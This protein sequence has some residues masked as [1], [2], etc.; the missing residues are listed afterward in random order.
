MTLT[1]FIDEYTLQ[2]NQE[3][4]LISDSYIAKTN[5]DSD[6][7]NMMKYS[8]LSNGKR[9]RPLLTLLIIQAFG[10]KINTNL[11]KSALPV[12]LIHAYSLVHDDLPDMDDDEYRRGELTT[13][14]KF[15]SDNAIL[16]GDALLTHAFLY[17]SKLPIESEI[18]IKLIEEMSNSAQEMVLGQQKDIAQINVDS[19]NKLENIHKLKTSALLRYSI[20]AGYYLQNKKPINNDDLMNLTTFAN[21]YGIAYQLVDDFK[22]LKQNSDLKKNTALNFLSEIDLKKRIDFL[23][24]Q[25]IKS[26]QKISQFDPSFLIELVNKL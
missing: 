13:W 14:K 24:F 23:K 8:L 15:G 19:L 6:L 5:G 16:V 1:N 11:V 21:N 17:L 20:L 22:D 12:E 26:L 10:E 2:I 3:L 7:F 4:N 18:L 25:S 9:V